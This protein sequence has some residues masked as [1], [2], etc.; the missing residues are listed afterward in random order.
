MTNCSL[1]V[2]YE[3][4]GRLGALHSK[5]RVNGLWGARCTIRV[6]LPSLASRFRCRS[7][8]LKLGLKVE[9]VSSRV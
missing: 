5:H 2:G 3:F 6:S 8:S 7:L 1:G 4:L 9:G